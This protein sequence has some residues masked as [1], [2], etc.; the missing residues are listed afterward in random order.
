MC[1]ANKHKIFIVTNESK[2]ASIIDVIDTY[3]MFHFKLDLL[4]IKL[5]LKSNK[6]R[7]TLNTSHLNIKLISVVTSNINETL[8]YTIKI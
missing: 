7:L 8:Y 4:R 2:H 5:L 6:K 3:R 1:A